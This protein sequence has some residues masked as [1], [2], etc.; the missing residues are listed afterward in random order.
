KRGNAPAAPE[1][2]S[3]DE[4][5][6][7]F[8]PNGTLTKMTGRGHTRI[9]QT[10]ATGTRQTTNGDV[11]VARLRAAGDAKASGRNGNAGETQIESATVDGNVVLTQQ[12]PPKAGTAQPEMRATAG[13]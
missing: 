2:M 13:H 11:L 4:V 12:P 10:T 6:G 9:A 7:E 1:N 3:A 8:G 5:T